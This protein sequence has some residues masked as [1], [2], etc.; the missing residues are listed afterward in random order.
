MLYG[1]LA[2]RVKSVAGFEPMQATQPD[3]TKRISCPTVLPAEPPKLPL[4][5]SLLRLGNMYV[6]ELCPN[7]RL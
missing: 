6:I 1:I 2:E 3:S 4:S 5:A 7:E